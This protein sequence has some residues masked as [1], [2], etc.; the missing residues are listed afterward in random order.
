MTPNVD[1]RVSI[2]IPAFH[3]ERTIAG[4]L[5]ALDAQAFR[6]FEVIVV[7]S[8]PDDRTAR[9]IEGFPQVV[10]LRSTERLMPHAARNRGVGHARG[11]LFVFTD[12]DIIM[13][14]DWLARLVGAHEASGAIVV[15]SIECHGT[16]FLDNAI[17]LCK[18]ARFLPAGVSRPIDMGP[19]ANLLVPR[20]VFEVLGGFPDAL[21]GDVTFSRAAL[22]A[23]FALRFEP[24][25]AVAHH[26]V[27]ALPS[28][29]K[30]R[31]ERGQLHGDMRVGSFKGGRAQALGFLAASILPLRLSRILLLTAGHCWRA[32]CFRW[33][34]PSLPVVV[35]GHAATLVGESVAY[36][37]AV[38]VGAGAEGDEMTVATGVGRTAP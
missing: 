6:N 20:Q 26:H 37:R 9:E 8:S 18:F 25:A 29:L 11:S 21:L 7:D 10:L 31:F 13:P 5:A 23:G 38:I 19:T 12:P 16:R 30:E 27:H 34:L 15:G 17:H 3:S 28:F 35:L 24:R 22:G 2:V 32:E 1:P 33:Y 14:P 4:T 36:A